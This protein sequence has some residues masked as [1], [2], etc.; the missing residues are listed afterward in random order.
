MCVTQCATTPRAHA[1]PC[2]GLECV[3]WAVLCSLQAM[4]QYIELFVK[5]A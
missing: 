3:V 1:V 2:V 5:V 4:T